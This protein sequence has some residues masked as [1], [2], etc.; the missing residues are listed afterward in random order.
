VR[1]VIKNKRLHLKDLI[2]IV[3]TLIAVWLYVPLYKLSPLEKLEVNELPR[4]RAIEVSSGK[5]LFLVL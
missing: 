3:P 2:H 1:K 4:G 5:N